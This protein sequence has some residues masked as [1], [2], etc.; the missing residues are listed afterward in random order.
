METLFSQL[1]SIIQTILIGPGIYLWPIKWAVVMPGSA[2][3]RFTMGRPGKV[4]GPGLHLYTTCQSLAVEHVNRRTIVTDEM[5]TLT[6]DGV[7][8]AADA[9]IVYRI[10]DLAKY[11]ASSDEMGV[12]IASTAEALVRSGIQGATYTEILDP[13]TIEQDLG[14]TLNRE[15]IDCGAMILVARFQRLFHLDPVAR[16]VFASRAAGVE[17]GIRTDIQFTVPLDTGSGH[18]AGKATP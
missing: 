3:V 18:T 13:G 6:S 10:V 12:L 1:F 17:S 16:A 4:L 14:D 2:G 8:V 15:L 9:V 5:R 7:P 11:L